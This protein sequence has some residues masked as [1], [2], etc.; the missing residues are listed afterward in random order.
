[1]QGEFPSGC[2]YWTE[3]DGCTRVTIEKAGCVRP[4]QIVSEKSVVFSYSDPQ[5]TFNNA[6]TA[7]IN[8]VTGAKI[9]YPADLDES[10]TFE[11]N[12]HAFINSSFFGC[13]ADLYIT[14]DDPI[15]P[16]DQTIKIQS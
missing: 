3:A 6:I 12:A 1:M 5:S 16:L 14:S 15:Y 10:N 8:Q 4:G 13:I 9:M 2:A 7:C 11:V